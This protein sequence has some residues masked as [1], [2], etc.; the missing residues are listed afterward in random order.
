MMKR[1]LFIALLILVAGAGVYFA[2]YWINTQPVQILNAGEVS[3]VE[4]I[5]VR[6]KQILELV[7]AEGRTLAPDYKQVVCTEFVIKVIEKFTPLTTAEENKIRII[8][9]EDIPL[10]LIQQS[11]VIK[12]VHTSLVEA[13]K[14]EEVLKAEDV[15]PGDFVQFWNTYLGIPYGHCG[16]VFDVEPHKSI[17]IFSSHPITGGYGK[18]KYLWPDQVFF[19]RLK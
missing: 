19:V 1:S 13:R 6:N 8:T 3:D 16:V 2:C 15:R 4:N 12:G 18:Q 11:P 5:P 9:R 7:N 10:L 14:G 17:T